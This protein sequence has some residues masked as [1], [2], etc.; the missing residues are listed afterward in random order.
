MP[1]CEGSD[2]MVLVKVSL[3]VELSFNR[4]R[5][6]RSASFPA[7]LEEPKIGIVLSSFSATCWTIYSLSSPGQLLLSANSS[8]LA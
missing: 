6:Q 8:H 7:S 1:F 3:K 4:Q 2:G 5:S